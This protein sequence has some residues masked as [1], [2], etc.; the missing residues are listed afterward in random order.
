M[1]YKYEK[2]YHLNQ[3]QSTALRNIADMFNSKSTATPISLVHGK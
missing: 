3:D 2:E 1:V